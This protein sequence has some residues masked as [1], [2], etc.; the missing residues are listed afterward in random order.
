MS[1]RVHPDDTGSSSKLPS[2]GPTMPTLPTWCVD[3]RL[4]P[5]TPPSSWKYVVGAHQRLPPVTPPS[6]WKYIPPIAVKA[7]VLPSVDD[8]CAIPSA[9]LEEL[10]SRKSTDSSLEH[11][12]PVEE[13]SNYTQFEKDLQEQ[14]PAQQRE[15]ESS[16]KV[17]DTQVA[18]D[19]K[20]SDSETE[21][22]PLM[23]MMCDRYWRVLGTQVFLLI[24]YIMLHTVT[25]FHLPLS[26][27][28]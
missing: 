8:D 9:R 11:D 12:I 4:P 25:S 5:V 21:P 23:A 3:Q 17:N 16:S 1:A 18:G 20:E 26:D 2:I 28:F 14:I 24:V 6:S 22:R 19:N 15:N 7:S 27:W 10:D 13:D